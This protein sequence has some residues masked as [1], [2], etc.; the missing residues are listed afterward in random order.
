MKIPTSAGPSS[1]FCHS[2]PTRSGPPTEQGR[3]RPGAHSLRASSWIRV[4]IN[5]T[6][7]RG[8]QRR[9]PHI[10]PCRQGPGP[11]RLARSRSSRQAQK[12]QQGTPPPP[13]VRP[14]PSWWRWA[15]DPKVSRM[16]CAPHGGWGI[17]PDI[18]ADGDAGAAAA[19]AASAGVVPISLG[20]KKPGTRGFDGG[21]LP[22]PPGFVGAILRLDVRELEVSVDRAAFIHLP[23]EAAPDLDLQ[24]CASRNERHRGVLARDCRI[25][26]ATRSTARYVVGAEAHDGCLSERK[27]FTCACLT[28]GWWPVGG[29]GVQGW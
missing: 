16:A 7:G 22:P 9:P 24:N 2:F 18:L 21:S 5:G 4:R 10:L 14:V 28:T 20:E 25:S 19:A 27:P 23:G 15:R 6:R 26:A 11:V 29:G 17:L 1:T 13:W 3:E 12:T 8:R